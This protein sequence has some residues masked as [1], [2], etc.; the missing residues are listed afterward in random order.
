M[1]GNIDE[2]VVEMKFEGTSF[3]SGIEKA[4]L[5]LTKLKTG[6]SGLKGADTDV[7]N[8]DEAGKKFSLSGI[9]NGLANISSKFS[10][11]GILG[12]SVLGTLASKA[13]EVGLDMVR[14]FIIDPVKEGLQS[15]ETQ[16]NATKTILS[17][18]AAAGTTLPQIVKALANLNVYANLTVYNFGQMAAAIGTFTAAGVGLQTSVN[19]IKGIAN[20]AAFSGADAV[21]AQRVM[22][23]FSEALS[24][25]KLQLRQWQSAVNA[26]IGGKVFQNA[27]IATANAQGIAVDKIIAKAGSFRASLN[28]GWVTS[29]V[30]TQALSIFTGQLSAA[31]LRA[32]GYSAAEAKLLA[33][34][35]KT[36]LQAATQVRTISALFQDLKEEVA[37]AFAAIFKAL[38]G[39]IGQATTALSAIHNAAENAL[40]RPIY[41][42]AAIL[43]QFSNLG[44]RQAVI[45]GLANIFK[46]LGAVLVTVGKAYKDV[47]PETAVGGGDELVKLAKD[48]ERI[49]AALIPG[50]KAL[51]EI[52][53]IF[54]GLFSAV[55]IVLDVIGDIVS[56][57]GHV[58]GAATSAGPGLLGLVA[59]LAQWI[60]DVRKWLESGNALV[61]FFQILGKIIA[62]PVKGI[63]LLIGLFSGLGG[64]ASKAAT[65][66][67]S[68]VS[69]IGAAFSKLADEI[70]KAI[71]S[72]NFQKIVDILDQLLVGGVLLSVRKL[73][74]KFGAGLGDG[75]SK[76]IFD[77]I[78]ESFEGLTNTL[79]SMQTKLKAGILKEIAISVALLAGSLFILSLINVKGLTAALSAITILFANLMLTLTAVTKGAGTTGV[80]KMV[81]IGVALNLFAT[82]ILI[83]AGAVAILAQF[84]LD[85]LAKGISSIVAL[86]ATL[87]AA[88]ALMTAGKGLI[89]SAIALNLFA[90]AINI[91]AI[92]VAQLGKLD[93]GTLAKGIGAIAA[94]LLILGLFSKFSGDTLI[95][96]ALSM[97]ILSAALLV[98]T[99]AVK[100][101]GSLPTGVLVKG[102]LA[103]AASLV[104]MALGM[105][106]MSGSLG[107]AA[108]LVVA[109]AALLILSKT[110]TSFGKLSWSQI[111]KS[112]V[113][114]AGALLI[115]AGAMILMTEALPGAAAL[116]VVAG[117]L[118]ILTPIL[119]ALGG[120]SWEAIG[121]GLATLAGLFAVI[122]I[123]GLLL[124]PV[125]P[126]LLGLGLAI[127][128]IGVGVLA[129]G[130]GVGVLAVGLTAL[131]VA[132]GASGAAIVLFVKSLI[133][134]LPEIFGEVG[135]AIGAFAKA[136]AGAIAPMTAAIAAILSA[137]LEAVIKVAPL[138]AKAFQ[139]V[140]TAILGIINKDAGPIVKT[141]ANL[142]LLLLSSVAKYTPKFV[143]A[144]VSILVNLL[145]GIA[146]QVPKIVGAA[147]NIITSFIAAIGAGALKIAKA[148]VNMVIS[149]LNGLA[150][151]LNTDSPK[152]DAAVD[153]LA[154]AII[155]GI[156]NGL[157]SLAGTVVSAL[158]NIVK[159][160]VQ[161]A[162]NWTKSLSPSKRTRDELGIP[163]VQGI[164]VGINQAGS[165]VTD[166]MIG[167]TS[168][169][170]SSL[171]NTLSNLNDVVNG[172][173]DLQPKITPV[174]DL[175]EAKKGFSQLA[176]LSK[177]QLISAGTSTSSVASISAANALAATQAG[178]LTGTKEATLQFNQ[179]NTSPV[180]LSAVDIYRKTKNQISA[181]KGVLIGNAHVG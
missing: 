47:F 118:A 137:I 23:E 12:V 88:A 106:L 43:Q 159:N 178:L 180:A 157:A 74:N 150:K 154:K 70:G 54:E 3:L 35:G 98:M 20:L 111:G 60:I 96:T 51:S 46:S 27:L 120:L 71:Q 95:S 34:Q 86:L 113:E 36:A 45:S 176:G 22:Q 156:I 38:I 125:I 123:A 28:K 24:Q 59:V 14:D 153:N 160:A 122:G 149:L 9:A 168:V 119:I 72:G 93:F 142:L 172:S 90:V 107:G 78:K 56:G 44:G 63:G 124:G 143:S 145:L 87:V 4:L 170:I 136:L 99:Q 32:M 30:L 29:S 116:L 53:I 69:K 133:G 163:M 144:G 161:G 166:A 52:Q 101:L 162:K 100:E 85:Q 152:L 177:N 110:I 65:A 94:L 117:A 91:L 49:T 10:A 108:A 37:T 33:E 114:L 171:K 127:A 42:L 139:V 105:K 67:S 73:I 66:G 55:K 135:I 58:G 179:Y 89:T 2:R 21:Q 151:E 155:N 6:L 1:S 141:F 97:V 92:A 39:N 140:L 121:K 130:A 174:V 181:A 104:V 173:L 146:K 16:L 41:L 134:L 48:F 57:F 169:A 17:N 13:T 138:A 61:T 5:S 129:A 167:V 80:A 62:L 131:A 15:Y 103:I 25:N 147:V 81:A 102:I 165:L 132:I 109:S 148:G 18:T 8:L 31:Q 26:G 11:F 64:A 50:K 126:V 40:T 112:L 19:A 164:A 79:Q 68:F 77:T 83:L 75:E 76:G 84:N 115:I 7:N 128:L 82:A 158:V 175:T